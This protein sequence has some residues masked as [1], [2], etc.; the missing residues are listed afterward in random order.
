VDASYDEHVPFFTDKQRATINSC[1]ALPAMQ[2]R[3]PRVKQKK[4]GE[5][6][7]RQ[8]LFGSRFGEMLPW[9]EHRWGQ[10]ASELRKRSHATMPTYAGEK[11]SLD[12]GC[13]NAVLL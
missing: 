3:S 13:M 12:S 2:L 10:K 7:M 1:I 9:C 6:Q 11:R 5:S 8:R 4:G